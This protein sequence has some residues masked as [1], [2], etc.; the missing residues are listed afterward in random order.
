[1]D[2]P[3]DGGTRQHHRVG[4]SEALYVLSVPPPMACPA[5]ACH[6]SDGMAVQRDSRGRARAG[7]GLREAPRKPFEPKA[8]RIGTRYLT[9]RPRLARHQT[10]QVPD[11]PGTRHTK[12]VGEKPEIK[13]SDR[14]G[15]PTAGTGRCPFPDP[16]LFTHAGFQPVALQPLSRRRPLSSTGTGAVCN[17]LHGVGRYLAAAGPCDAVTDIRAMSKT[18]KWRL[19]TSS[20]GASSSSRPS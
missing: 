16:P 12:G 7:C 10:C 4:E 15:L 5:N 14:L 2:R 11:L 18:V 17:E 9:P 6:V 20:S 8:P 13:A 3:I 19:P 1:M